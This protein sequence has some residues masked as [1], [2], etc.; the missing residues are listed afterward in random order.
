MKE[1]LRSQ[2]YALFTKG[3]SALI[4]P[5]SAYPGGFMCVCVCCPDMMLVLLGT[6][7]YYTIL[8]WHIWAIF[9]T[10]YIKHLKWSLCAFVRRTRETPLCRRRLANYPGRAPK[11]KVNNGV[12]IRN[13]ICPW[14]I[15]FVQLT[16]IIVEHQAWRRTPWITFE[17][18]YELWLLWPLMLITESVCRHIHMHI[19]VRMKTLHNVINGVCRWQNVK[20]DKSERTLRHLFW[21]SRGVFSL[22]ETSEKNQTL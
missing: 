10:E 19:M 9:R 8:P 4:K 5:I 12:R 11:Q 13:W 6:L 21:N 18:Q 7:Y 15:V 20:A 16:L 3:L 14:P 17:W 22:G 2:I 1:R